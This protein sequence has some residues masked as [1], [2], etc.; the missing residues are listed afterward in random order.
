ML[1]GYGAWFVMGR[2][3]PFLYAIKYANR[4]PREYILNCPSR[5]AHPYVKIIMRGGSNRAEIW[6]A[7]LPHAGRSRGLDGKDVP[8]WHS[9]V[10]E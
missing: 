2:V 10:S 7:A 9:V 1:V 5:Q 8:Y 3:L 6:R 4:V